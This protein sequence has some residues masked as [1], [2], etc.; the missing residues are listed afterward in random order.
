MQGVVEALIA[1]AVNGDVVAQKAVIALRVAPRKDNVLP[2][3]LPLLGSAADV[4]FCALAV[5]SEVLRGKLTPSEGQAV[6]D[7]LAGVAKIAEAGE[8]AERLAVLEKLALK[9][10]AAGKLSWGDL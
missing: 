5:T 4:T 9:S 1:N 3:Q 2:V 7:L 10:A 6:L 8:I